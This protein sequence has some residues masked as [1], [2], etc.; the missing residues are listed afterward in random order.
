MDQIWE[1]FQVWEIT[2]LGTEPADIMTTG[3][4]M[5]KPDTF[6]TRLQALLKERKLTLMQAAKS[7][8]ISKST[9][10][11][12]TIGHSPNDFEALD[13]LCQVLHSD[14]N[15][16][17]L[18]KAPAPSDSKQLSVSEVFAKDSVLFDG[19]AHI[20]VT[21]LVPRSNVKAEDNDDE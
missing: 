13:R 1:S 19:F 11:N 9:I 20:K 21:K 14:I 6:A 12:W 10:H 4:T 2:L 5:A 8:K 16:L 18:G 7:A 3:E 17:L 15:Y